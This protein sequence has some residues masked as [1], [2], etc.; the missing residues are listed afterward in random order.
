MLMCQVGT[1]KLEPGEVPGFESM[2][3][4]P[5]SIVCSVIPHSPSKTVCYKSHPYQSMFREGIPIV[6]FKTENRVFCLGH[7]LLL[8]IPELCLCSLLESSYTDY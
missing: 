8:Q 6:W 7:I 2:M 1:K 3:V 4:W 5:Q